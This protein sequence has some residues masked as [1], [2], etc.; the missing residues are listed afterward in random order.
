MPDVKLDI[1]GRELWEIDGRASVGGG[2]SHENVPD[3]LPYF[4]KADILVVPLRY[5]AGTRV[6]ILEAMAHGL[7]GVTTT[8]GC[9]GIAAENGEHLLIADTPILFGFIG[10]Q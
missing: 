8:K 10:M 9:E 7:P 6:K 4:R 5:G 3:V 2:E 1:V